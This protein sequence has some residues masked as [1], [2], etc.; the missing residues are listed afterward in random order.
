MNFLKLVNHL[1]HLRQ[2]KNL[3]QVLILIYSSNYFQQLDLFFLS[4]RARIPQVI[5]ILSFQRYFCINDTYP[6]PSIQSTGEC[7][8]GDKYE[9]DETEDYIAS[10]ETP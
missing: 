4:E 1:Y 2:S 5:I 6:A 3:N 8:H 7:V 9:C 10:V